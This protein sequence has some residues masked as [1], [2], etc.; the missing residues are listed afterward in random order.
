M[1]STPL[2]II[3]AMIA[4]LYAIAS[5]LLGGGNELAALCDYLLLAA[6]FV[7]L[8]FPRGSIDQREVNR[9]EA[10]ENA[11]VLLHG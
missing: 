6:V 11:A 4:A 5:I 9:F 3:A 10:N 8:V 1:P 2:A 7:G